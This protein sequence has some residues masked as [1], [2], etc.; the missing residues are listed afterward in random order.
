MNK[1]VES[2]TPSSQ[3]DGVARILPDQ[4]VNEEVIDAVDLIKNEN[5]NEYAGEVDQAA[6][7]GQV[8]HL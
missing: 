4:E 2:N 6:E 3:V 1:F 7:V 8:I 5:E